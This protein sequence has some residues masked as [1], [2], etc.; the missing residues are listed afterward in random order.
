MALSLFF[1][2][3][4]ANFKIRQRRCEIVVQQVAALFRQAVDGFQQGSLFFLL[5]DLFFG[6]LSP[7]RDS[8]DGRATENGAGYGRDASWP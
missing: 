8:T 1:V 6:R 4:L 3:H 5:R 2:H 7:I